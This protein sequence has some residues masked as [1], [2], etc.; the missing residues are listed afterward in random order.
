MKIEI[1]E[2]RN[3]AKVSRSDGKVSTGFVVNQAV[4]LR[5][6][7]R[8]QQVITLELD[9]WTD[10]EPVSEPAPKL[11]VRDITLK[12]RVDTSEADEKFARIG[13]RIQRLTE[14]ARSIAVTGV[15]K[16]PVC[17]G[18]GRVL[19]D[20]SR[21]EFGACHGCGGKGWVR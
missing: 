8:E 9:G 4:H 20:A 7:E 10:P 11:E 13:E 1:D 12:L 15:M 21:R 3:E 14:A 17:E 16:C 2:S 19:V 6:G 5:P 18:R